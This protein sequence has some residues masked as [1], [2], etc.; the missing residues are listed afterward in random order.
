MT[1]LDTIL[2]KA[3]RTW[4]GSNDFRLMPT[5]P[6]ATS[7]A[8]ATFG[9]AAGGN[10]ATLGYTW[11]HPAD[12]PQEGVIV[13]GRGE[14]DGEYAVLWAD[15]WHQAT[16]RTFAAT[17]DGDTLRF[18]YL[19]GETWRWEVQLTVTAD[20]LGL[21]MRNVVPEGA[22]EGMQAGPYD[23]MVMRLGAG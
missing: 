21:V 22:D 16:A 2:G 10:V 17:A 9:V 15:S 7:D 1:F 3:G 19:Y 13:L 12:G 4:A 14:G 18:D 8:A 23:A 5:D 20:A 11:T 6:V